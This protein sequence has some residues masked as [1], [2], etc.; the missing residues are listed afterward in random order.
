MSILKFTAQDQSILDSEQKGC[1]VNT[2]HPSEIEALA[3]QA[4]KKLEEMG[5]PKAK[6]AGVGFVYHAAG[7]WANS[8]GNR[9]GAT[10]VRLRRRSKD[11]VVTRIVRVSVNPKEK[12]VSRLFLNKGQEEAVLAHYRQEMGYQ[13]VEAKENE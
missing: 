5:L 10:L 12:E 7:P 1:R 11:W 9:Q 2:L 8:Y 13:V 3:E 4:E 6:R